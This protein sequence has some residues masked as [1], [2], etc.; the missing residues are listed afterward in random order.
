MNGTHQLEFTNFCGPLNVQ[1][2]F[3]FGCQLSALPAEGLLTSF[4]AKLLNHSVH[5]RWQLCAMG[6]VWT[7]GRE[8][9][10]SVAVY[11]FLLTFEG[12][13]NLLDCRFNCDGSRAR[14]SKGT[15]IQ[16]QRFTGSV[17]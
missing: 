11:Q 9:D 8:W 3:E 6:A 12:A 13:T 16:S 5:Y 7:W 17:I 10:A 4:L 14:K 2:F 1:L 15:F